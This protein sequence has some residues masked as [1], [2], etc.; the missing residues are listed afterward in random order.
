MQDHLASLQVIYTP[1]YWAFCFSSSN[2]L[3]SLLTFFQQLF[4]EAIVCVCVYVRACVDEY[5]S[6]D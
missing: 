3:F 5:M 6:A 1:K 2:L 4:S